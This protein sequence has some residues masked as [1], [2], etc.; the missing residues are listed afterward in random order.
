MNYIVIVLYC[1]GIT[2]L[3]KKMNFLQ[4]SVLNAKE[5]R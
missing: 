3:F 4:Q 2:L 5:N 1:L